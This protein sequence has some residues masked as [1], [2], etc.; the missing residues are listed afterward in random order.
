MSENDRVTWGTR[1]DRESN[2]GLLD[3]GNELNPV[4]KERTI[5]CSRCGNDAS[6]LLQMTKD[7]LSFVL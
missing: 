2:V 1:K 4:L 7:L 6:D 3:F 5:T